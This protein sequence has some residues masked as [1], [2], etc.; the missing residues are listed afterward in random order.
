MPRIRAKMPALDGGAIS[1]MTRS[2]N[3]CLELGRLDAEALGCGLEVAGAALGQRERRVGHA[4]QL[5]ALLGPGGRERLL[6]VL[7]RRLGVVLLGGARA[8]DR[9]G[10]GAVAG[11]R[12]ELLVAAGLQ[13][14]HRGE[15]ALLFDADG[16]LLLRHVAQSSARRRPAGVLDGHE[17]SRTAG[18]ASP[19]A[20]R[21]GRC[22]PE[23]SGS[24]CSKVR[25][26]SG[27]APIAAAR[28]SGPPSGSPAATRTRASRCSLHGLEVEARRQRLDAARVERDPRPQE[29]ACAAEDDHA[30]VEELLALDPR[31]ERAARRTGRVQAPRAASASSTNARGAASRAHR[32]IDVPGAGGRRVR[33]EPLVRHQIDGRG[34][35]ARRSKTRR[36]ARVG[37]AQRRSER[38]QHVVGDQREGLARARRRGRDRCGAD[39]ARR[40]GRSAR[41]GGA[42]RAGSGCAGCGRRSW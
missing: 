2:P 39:R 37:R 20:P 28:R 27:N 9:L 4:A 21:T 3:S 1:P 15:L 35:R 30:D 32:V 10:G 26:A 42:R 40:R 25:R 33:T 13:R 31:H 19:R 18:R 12:R 22:E 38:Q 29:T 24:P 6:E 14:L 11:L 34:D 8:E 23:R 41:S 16:A 17:L 5:H 36:Q 7:A